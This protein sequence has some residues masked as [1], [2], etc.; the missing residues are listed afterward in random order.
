MNHGFELLELDRKWGLKL[1]QIRKRAKT[2]TD[3]VFRYC[4]MVIYTKLGLKTPKIS[5]KKFSE[6]DLQKNWKNWAS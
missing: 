5:R 1:I 2:S 3:N 6:N 4:K